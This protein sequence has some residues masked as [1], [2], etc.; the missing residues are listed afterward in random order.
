MPKAAIGT[1]ILLQGVARRHNFS[2]K[3]AGVLALLFAT[4]SA[5]EV[6]RFHKEIGGAAFD[7]FHTFIPPGIQGLL[8]WRF[9]WGRI[10]QPAD[11]SP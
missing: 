1:D 7:V 8:L 4:H 9:G 2:F 3:L 6:G 11:L 10:V 5:V